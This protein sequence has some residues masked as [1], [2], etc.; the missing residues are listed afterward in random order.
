MENM[1]PLRKQSKK[2]Q[3]DFHS[4]QRGSWGTV[5][6]VSRVEKAERPMTAAARESAPL[7][8]CAACKMRL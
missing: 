7:R 3:R 8:H 2:A 4:R 6:P 5:K 1:I